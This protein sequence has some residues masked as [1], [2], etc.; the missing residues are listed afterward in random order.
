MKWVDYREAL[1]I[2]FNDDKKLQMLKNKMQAFLDEARDWFKAI[3]VFSYAIMVGEQLHSK[4][5]YEVVDSFNSTTTIAAYI[6][7]CVAFFN[8]CDKHN[9]YDEND[10]LSDTKTVFLQFLKR[11]LESLNIPYEIV[12]DSD[13]IF[14][15]PKGAKELDDALVSEPLEWLKTYPKSRTAFI[16]AHK[17]YAELNDDNASDVAD[18]LRKAL[19]SFFQEFFGGGKT[20]E[21][22][23]SDY[24]TYLKNRGVPTEISNNFATLL[25]SY[26]DY[27]NNYAKHH[28]KSEKNILEY[29][30]YQTGNIVRLLITLKQGGTPNAD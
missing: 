24:G 28:D 8:S 7:K 14:I 26:T 16:K 18:K 11:C 12:E 9:T 2:G 30:L 29:L 13:G 1:G 22:Y 10:K 17:D 27:I 6:S 19:E 25:K 21:N 4:K 23:K 5:M 15:F 3:D 20:L